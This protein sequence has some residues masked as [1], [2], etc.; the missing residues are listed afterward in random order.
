MTRREWLA[1]GTLLLASACRRPKG[2]G[3]PGYALIAASGDNSLSVVDLQTFRFVKPVPLRAAPAAVIPGRSVSYVLTPS[4]GTVHVLD[5]KLQLAG[6][7]QLA[8]E[9]SEI[10]LMPDGKRL[11]AVSAANRELIEA[12]PASLK[13]TRRHKLGAEP[14]GLDVVQTGYVAISTGKNGTVELFNLTAGQ[15]NRTHLSGQ[16]GAV[17][18]RSDGQLLLVANFHDRSLTALD[19]PSLQVVADLPLAMQPQNLCFNFDQGQFFVSGEG[20]DGIAIVFPFKVLEVE[21]TILAGRDPG[22]MACSES[23]ADLFVAS[24]SGSDV[25]ILNID[26]RKI[27]GIVDVGETPRYIAIT[28]DSQYALVLNETSGHMAVIHIPANVPTVRADRYKMGAS[29][30][31]MIPVGDKPVHAAIVPRLLG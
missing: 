20:M 22:V 28:P 9:L 19:V 27:I 7:R 25:C 14:L 13:V 26:T 1:C 30:F 23:P 21:Q 18:F 12:D 31:T 6:S 17:R 8:E 16:I 5:G 11:V 15:H 2:C 10:R 24:H 3:Y 29:L 4:T